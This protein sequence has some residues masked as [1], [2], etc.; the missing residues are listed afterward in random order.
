MNKNDLLLELA[1]FLSGYRFHPKF[2]EEITALLLNDL[3]GKETAFFKKLRIQLNYISSFGRNIDQVSSNH[4]KLKGV[5]RNFYSIRIKAKQFN[6]RLLLCFDDN[7][8]PQFLS[9]FFERAGKRKTDY[10]TFIPVLENRYKELTGGH[11]D[12]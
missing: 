7:D 12:E 2:L 11:E 8:Q 1:L 9:A 10:S 5:S 6:I 3:S 4:E